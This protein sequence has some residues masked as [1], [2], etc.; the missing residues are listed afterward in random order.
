MGLLAAMLS[1]TALCVIGAHGM[2]RG[3]TRWQRIGG[4]LFVSGTLTIC[5]VVLMGK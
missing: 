2:F 4:A 3:N 1:G 5:A